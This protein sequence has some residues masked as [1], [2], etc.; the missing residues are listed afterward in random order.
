MPCSAQSWA[1]N[2]PLTIERERRGAEGNKSRVSGRQR[3]GSRRAGRNAPLLPACPTETVTA[4]ARAANQLHCHQTDEDSARMPR[5]GER[6][7]WPDELGHAITL[8]SVY[9]QSSL[10]ILCECECEVSGS[11]SARASSRWLSSRETKERRSAR[12]G[13]RVEACRCTA[14]SHTTQQRT[15]L[16]APLVDSALSVLPTFS[17]PFALSHS[18]STR[19]EDLRRHGR[20]YRTRSSTPRPRSRLRLAPAPLSLLFGRM[21]RFRRL[22]AQLSSRVARIDTDTAS[23]CL[24]SRTGNRCGR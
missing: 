13:R 22:E 1:Q 21:E 24:A 16:P 5:R 8:V 11:T 14:T 17:F 15:L 6:V 2:S 23:A 12:S 9:S 4:G 20:V 10:G 19:S 7:G 3:S 18:L